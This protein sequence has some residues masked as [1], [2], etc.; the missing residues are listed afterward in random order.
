M[1]TMP[2]D[3]SDLYLAP[4]ALAV[5]AVLVELGT[6]SDDDLAFQISVA[7][8]CPDYSMTLR[9]EAVLRA[10]GHLVDDLHGWTAAW[11]PRGIRLT[12]G[13]HALV[14]GVPANV[15]AY[16]EGQPTPTRAGGPTPT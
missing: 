16:R 14:L 8:D 11:D 2:H 10:V 9:E 1:T 3:V 15:W 7:S 13:T 4:T 5:D 12:H 6:L